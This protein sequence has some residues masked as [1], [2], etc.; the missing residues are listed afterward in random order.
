MDQKFN[1]QVFRKDQANIIAKNRILADI[2]SVRLAYDSAGYPAGQVL[3]RYTSGPKSG[4]FAKYDDAGPSGTDTAACILL[5]D[6][7]VSAFD[8][9]SDSFLA[10]GVFKGFL[11]KD[12]LTGL[13]SSAIT[14]FGGKTQ[15]AAD[16]IN[17]FVF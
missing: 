6:V 12:N 11:Y 4:Q 2:D 17:I 5:D 8:D 9:S 15:I 7:P 16:G 1:G 13:T 3:G 10:R 14:D